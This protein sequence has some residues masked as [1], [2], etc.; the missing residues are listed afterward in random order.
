MLCVQD[1]AV[2]LALANISIDDMNCGRN[3]ILISFAGNTKLEQCNRGRDQYLGRTLTNWRGDMRKIE[4][5]SVR[6]IKGLYI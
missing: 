2:F 5:D 3:N 1:Y 4:C 6:K